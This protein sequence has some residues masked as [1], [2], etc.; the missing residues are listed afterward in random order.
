MKLTKTILT[1]LIILLATTTVHAA[2]LTVLNTDPAPPRSGEYVDIT[3]RVNQGVTERELQDAELTPLE[4][5]LVTPISQ[6]E[7][8]PSIQEGDVI[9]AT[10]TV[11]IEDRAPEGNLPV[12]F[13][14]SS[15]HSTQQF[16]KRIQIV[17][18]FSDP[19]LRVGSVRTTPQELLPDTDNNEL[20]VTL[21]NVGDKAAKQVVL[22]LKETEGLTESYAYS[23][24]DTAATIPPGESHT[25]T[26]QADIADNLRETFNTDLDAEYRVDEETGTERL[27]ETPIDIRIPITEA[28]YLTVT[29]V[30]RT[31]SFTPGSTGNE[32]LVT[33]ENQGGRDA[34][35]A[36]I[37][38]FPD[39]SYPFIFDT[40]TQYVSSILQPGENTT[41]PFEVEVSGDADARSYQIRTEL[42]SLIDTTRYE[43]RDQLTLSVE[44]AQESETGYGAYTLIG[45]IIVVAAGLGYYLKRRD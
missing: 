14:L 9:T 8:Y 23:L 7:T 24:Q 4:T 18:S 38:L 44:G 6:P 31:G 12:L 13:E 10:F 26:F 27:V 34:E 33:V 25:F 35:D 20:R 29:G 11:Y 45:G 2:T 3:V 19:V 40:T 17:D 5:G 43:R 16:N 37:R 36:R 1:A 39:V 30:E 28:P 42:E 41:V 22:T 21:N 15:D 32:V